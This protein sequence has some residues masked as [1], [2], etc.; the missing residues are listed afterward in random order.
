MRYVAGDRWDPA[1]RSRRE[2]PKHP[3]PCLALDELNQYVNQLIND[4]RE[5]K[6]SITV[7]PTGGGANDK[8][9]ELRRNMIWQIQIDSKA[10]AANIQAFERGAHR[11]HG[12][13][14]NNHPSVTPDK[15]RQK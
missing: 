14:P 12:R 9:A 8:T 2:D 15:F 1:E 13:L 7:I 4:V 10:Q 3:R 5:S 11:S 6:R